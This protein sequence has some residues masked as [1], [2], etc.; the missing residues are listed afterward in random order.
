MRVFTLISRN[1]YVHY[2]DP[3]VEHEQEAGASITQ[4]K[5]VG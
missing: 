2:L 5:R 4:L 1:L 3:L